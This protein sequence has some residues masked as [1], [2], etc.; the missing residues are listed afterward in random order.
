MHGLTHPNNEKHEFREDELWSLKMRIPA[1]AA[2]P[3]E[4][5]NEVH[6]V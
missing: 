2:E 6:H 1:D 5:S 4:R 3:S